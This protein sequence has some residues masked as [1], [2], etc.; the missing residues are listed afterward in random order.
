MPQESIDLITELAQ[1]TARGETTIPKTLR[2]AIRED[3]YLQKLPNP[4]P[5]VS[6]TKAFRP[7]P[8]KPSSQLAPWLGANQIGG[9]TPAPTQQ[10]IKISVLGQDVTEDYLAAKTKTARRKVF[11]T[12]AEEYADK[13]DTL[14]K[15]PPPPVVDDIPKVVDDIP[16]VLEQR[17]V[18]AVHAQ[19]DPMPVEQN[20]APVV[21]APSQPK[22]AYRDFRESAEAIGDEKG[23]QNKT[24]DEQQKIIDGA[25]QHAGEEEATRLQAVVNGDIALDTP[26]AP[27]PE[28][29]A[30]AGGIGNGSG[31]GNVADPPASGG[32]GKKRRR[33]PKYRFGFAP[34]HE[35]I[36]IGGYVMPSLPDVD[37]YAAK[38][39]HDSTWQEIADRVSARYPKLVR[40]I[41][42]HGTLA[43]APVEAQGV[44]YIEGLRDRINSALAP[45]FAQLDRLGT[46]D[47]L[48]GHKVEGKVDAILTNGD[49]TKVFVGQIAENPSRYQLTEEQ[50]EWLRVAQEINQAP[51]KILEGHGQKVTDYE[52]KTEFFVG[53]M[54]VGRYDSTGEIVELAYVPMADKRG[55]AGRAGTV[56]SRAFD[57]IED[58][59]A[60]GFMPEPSYSK[61]L[62]LRARS[63][64]REAVN[65]RVGH[66]LA[67][68]L[69][70]AHEGAVPG[71]A[72][73]P[74]GNKPFRVGQQQLDILVNTPKRG[75]Q[76]FQYRLEGPEAQK[77]QKFV[78]D[79]AHEGELREA[80]KW[81]RAAAVGGAEVRL[82][83]LT[84]DLSIFTIQGLQSWASRPFG[85]I[86]G[87]R[88]KGF[89][90]IKVTEGAILGGLRALL[91]P[92]AVR[93]V[94]A[95]LVDDF[96]QRGG[97]T[98]HPNLILDYGGYSEFTE[99]TQGLIR[100]IPVAGAIYE[101]FGLQFDYVR[102][103]MAL[104]HAELTEDAT[105]KMSD[106]PAKQAFIDAQDSMTN[107]L[108][109]R[110]STQ[111]LGISANQRMAEG[112]FALAPQY[113]RATFGLL[114]QLLEGNP[115]NNVR[116]REAARFLT[117]AYGTL[118]FLGVALT[119]LFGMSR[120][121]NREQITAQ[122][123]RF[124]NPSSRDFATVTVNLPG[125]N[126]FRAGLGG[127]PKAMLSLITELIAGEEAF[128]GREPYKTGL[129]GR[130]ETLY[131]FGEARPGPIL[132]VL[133]DVAKGEDFIGQTTDPTKLQG[134][135]RLI[136]SNALPIFLQN[137]I[138]ELD[139]QNWVDSLLKP[140]SAVGILGLNAR[141]FAVSDIRDR[142]ARELYPSATYNKL[143]SWEKTYVKALAQPELQR[144]Y[145]RRAANQSDDISYA[146]KGLQSHPVPNRARGYVARTLATDSSMDVAGKYFSWLRAD[147]FER[148]QQATVS[149]DYS[150]IFGE[151]PPELSEDE[152]SKGFSLWQEILGLDDED[153]KSRA[154]AAFERQFPPTSEVGQY[155]RRQ[156]NQRRVPYTLL[157]ELSNYSKSRGV[158]Y[159]VY[160]R[161]QELYRKV[162]AEAGPE[163]AKRQFDEYLRWS[164][165]IPD[166]M[167]IATEMAGGT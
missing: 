45:M 121:E 82:A 81:V 32:G 143:D 146:N 66:W 98:I 78:Q 131:R 118:A 167:Q 76:R 91:D 139:T 92:V 39:R 80:N 155:I 101:R 132:G 154:L 108:L 116:P 106:G 127:M 11:E 96:A 23:I 60:A 103:I 29:D 69:K 37:Q 94:R 77:L 74:G 53:R 162:N 54:M 27:K 152:V 112:I 134:L 4:D 70:Q 136:T 2:D 38:L 13:L 1:L 147:E 57:S 153:R 83:V 100:R 56:K 67:Q 50:Q 107:K 40:V 133:T 49:E 86:A 51:K 19:Q 61:T 150:L 120:G 85:M 124:L 87:P 99:A 128:T 166:L 137:A 63:A 159:S 111:S 24:P 119:V 164:F 20:P 113:Y 110:L 5:N 122:A 104:K 105:K 35:D 144:L 117:K 68:H 163:A 8:L 115:F 126:D 148:G 6:G 15:T 30:A 114:A 17:S 88:V 12:K 62:L 140:S 161:A 48:F 71:L 157:Q 10:D 46:E 141:D 130:F 125:D 79:I 109:G 160:A 18:E 28:P 97:H 3:E 123:K 36:D 138:D 149:D 142:T 59:L 95:K 84:A 31:S 41:N 47:A 42:A 21:D 102:D 145:E 64:G 55:L 14:P 26:P 75:V 25:R 72:V 151:R 16:K 34:V 65:I 135:R 90:G 22:D 158:I 9:T 93:K 165:M 129:G 156:T 7:A 43:H 44:I 33:T 89:K 73:V 58:A 52:H